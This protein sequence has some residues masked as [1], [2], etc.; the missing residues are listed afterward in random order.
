MSRLNQSNTSNHLLA[1][2]AADDF[3]RLSP[4]LE[5]VDLPVRFGIAQA[6]Q[7]IDFV[8]FPSSGIGSVVVSSEGHQAEI[9]L[10]GRDGF[11]PLEAVL[12]SDHKNHEVFMQNPGAGH[13]IKQQDLLAAIAE[14]PA[15]QLPLLRYVQAL[16][17]QTAFTALSNAV[18]QIDE[19]LARWLLM[20]H[21]RSDSYEMALTHDIMATT[22][23]VRR[24]SV[25]TALHVLEGNGF[26]CAER[27]Y[28]TIRRREAMEE[29]ASA[30]Y[31]LPEKEYRRANALCVWRILSRALAWRSLERAVT[32]L[33][34]AR[35]LPTW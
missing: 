17:V 9:G 10:F 13:R 21:D 12:G 35:S 15:I 32:R 7:A 26:I 4:H 19:R 27:G 29:F 23:A 14:R 18:H 24:P 16:R 3:A 22:L 28:V 31:G 30:A 1:L 8:Y 5:P 25:T 2:L 33:C 6:D 11:S 20:C 34:P